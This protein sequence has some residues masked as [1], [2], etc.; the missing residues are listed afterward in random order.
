MAG[1]GAFWYL[2][3]QGMTRQ[4]HRDTAEVGQIEGKVAE[5]I[6]AIET[7][8]Q[9]RERA[10]TYQSFIEN[11]EEQMPKGNVETW[12]VKQIS[13]LAIIHQVQIAN[14]ALQSISGDQQFS[15]S[16]PA[17]RFKH[18]RP[19]SGS[20]SFGSSRAGFSA[21]SAPETACRP[22]PLKTIR[23]LREQLQRRTAL[24]QQLGRTQALHRHVQGQ[25]L[26]GL[27]LG[28]AV[29]HRRQ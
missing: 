26:A 19:V 20:S 3:V 8:K 5:K 14:T 6:K 11:Y 1:F 21:A 16:H 27:Q 9:N 15:F 24:A 17:P 12:L 25:A 28:Q 7:E 23:Q 22:A 13:E 4:Q 29:Q 18:T 2:V 10:K